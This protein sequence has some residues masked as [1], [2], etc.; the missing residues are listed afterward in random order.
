M[1]SI[2]F[3]DPF[4]VVMRVTPS[5]PQRG[6]Q[7]KGSRPLDPRG[8]ESSESTFSPSEGPDRRPSDPEGVG[9]FANLTERFLPQK[10]K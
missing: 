8:Y 10:I 3:R 6:R 4:I 7:P 2:V 5:L 9:K 1:I